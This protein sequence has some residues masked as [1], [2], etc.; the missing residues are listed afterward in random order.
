M[1]IRTIQNNIAHAPKY[2]GNSVAG[3]RGFW[4]HD[5]SGDIWV[6]FKCSDR[7]TG[8]GISLNPSEPVWE[9]EAKP[10]GVCVCCGTEKVT[11]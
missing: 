1:N 9:D 8:R 4:H 7:L 11:A 3:L 5:A 6:C 2:S 10:Y